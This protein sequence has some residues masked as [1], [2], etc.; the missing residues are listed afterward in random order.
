VKV[1]LYFQQSFGDL[2]FLQA[3][4]AWGTWTVV[5]GFRCEEIHNELTS[6]NGNVDRLQNVL[7]LNCFLHGSFNGLGVWF[8]T[9]VNP[10]PILPPPTHG[11][12]DYCQ[13]LSNQ[14]IVRSTI[15]Y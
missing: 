7:T 15:S 8:E 2:P 5:R 6:E 13:G 4:Y 12:Q 1:S 3:W 10:V 11:L 9:T 14:C